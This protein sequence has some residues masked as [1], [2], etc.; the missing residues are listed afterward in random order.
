MDR[1]FKNFQHFLC[2][3]SAITVSLFLFSSGLRYSMEGDRKE[4][5]G[6]R[7]GE[8]DLRRLQKSDGCAAYVPRN[9]VLTVV[10]QSREHY[11]ADRTA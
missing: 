10:R 7:R 1:D 2:R 8:E 4:E 6:H 9:Y 11:K 3:F 5:E